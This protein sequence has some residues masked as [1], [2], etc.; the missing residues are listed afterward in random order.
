M[1]VV[2]Y[3]TKLH[4]P[5]TGVCSTWLAS[6]TQKDKIRD[7]KIPVWIKKATISFPKSLETPVILIGPGKFDENLTCLHLF[8]SERSVICFQGTGCAPF[9]SF[10]EERISKTE[11]GI[12]P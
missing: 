2:K 12:N 5:R 11:K 8:S 10:I 9:R 7:T 6:L 1:A 3:K 4:K